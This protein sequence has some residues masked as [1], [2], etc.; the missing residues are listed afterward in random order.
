MDITIHA[1]S[2]LTL[3]TADLDGTFERVWAGC[4]GVVQEPTEQPYDVRDGAIRGPVGNL[5]S[6][7]EM[8]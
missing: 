3:A 1:S 8:R 6:T 4:T 5:I 7:N 2:L